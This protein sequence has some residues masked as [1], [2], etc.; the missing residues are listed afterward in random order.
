MNKLYTNQAEKSSLSCIILQIIAEKSVFDTDIFKLVTPYN[1]STIN[2][3]LVLSIMMTSMQRRQR[4]PPASSSFYSEI[5]K[6]VVV[7]KPDVEVNIY[8]IH[9]AAKD[10]DVEVVRASLESDLNNVNLPD[11]SGYSPL[12]IA[13][14]AGQIN[15]LHLLIKAGAYVDYKDNRGNTALHHAA[16]HG[17]VDAITTLIE[18]GAKVNQTTKPR[19]RLGPRFGDSKFNYGDT[20]LHIAAR[21]GHVKIIC[22]LIDKGAIVNQTNNNGETP[23]LIAASNNQVEAISALITNGADL[24]QPD[25]YDR[26]PFCVAA[27][28]G[29]VKAIKL[30]KRLGVDVNR[31]SKYRNTALH[32]AARRGHIDV[33][34]TLIECF[35]ELNQRNITG[36]SPL[37]IAAQYGHVSVIRVML[38]HGANVNL[39]NNKVE[40]P[41]SI[42]TQHG[43]VSVIKALIEHGVTV[44]ITPLLI[45]IKLDNEDATELLIK[46]GSKLDYKNKYGNTLLH[47]AAR[48]GCLKA[49]NVLIKHGVDVNQPIKPNEI[50]APR[51]K[52]YGRAP[53]FGR[54]YM[55]AWIGNDG[56]TALY[57]AASRGYMEIINILIACGA[58]VYQPIKNG[59]TAYD[60]AVKK[61]YIIIAS[62]LVHAAVIQP[63]DDN[64]NTVLHHAVINNH[65]DMIAKMKSVANRFKKWS[66]VTISESSYIVTGSLLAKNNNGKTAFDLIQT[67]E[68]ESDAWI[69]RDHLRSFDCAFIPENNQSHIVEKLRLRE[70]NFISPDNYQNFLQQ[71]RYDSKTLLMLAVQLGDINLVRKLLDKNNQIDYVGEDGNTAAH[72]AVLSNR[73]QIVDLFMH[74]QNAAVIR[75]KT[76]LDARTPLTLAI[77]QGKLNLIKRMIEKAWIPSSESVEYLSPLHVAFRNTDKD[78]LDYLIS[79]QKNSSHPFLLKHNNTDILHQAIRSKSIYNVMQALKMLRTL[80]YDFKPHNF[81]EKSF[82]TADTQ[83]HYYAAIAIQENFSQALRELFKKKINIGVTDADELSLLRFAIDLGHMECIEAIVSSL[84]AALD[85]SDTSNSSAIK[86]IVS[87][88]PYKM[89]EF[90]FEKMQELKLIDKLSA[91][92][93][94]NLIN[95]GRSRDDY[96]ITNLCIKLFSRANTINTLN[97]LF[98]LPNKNA[99]MAIQHQLSTSFTQS[100][101]INGQN[102]LHHAVCRSRKSLIPILIDKGVDVYGKD[103]DGYTPFHK[104]V[105]LSKK[106][107]VKYFFGNKAK[108]RIELKSEKDKLE[109]LKCAID[110]NN[111]NIFKMILSLFSKDEILSFKDDDGSPIFH[112][113][114][115]S[116]NIDYLKIYIRR[117]P[118][119]VAENSTSGDTILHVLARHNEAFAYAFLDWLLQNTNI[120]EILNKTNKQNCY[121]PLHVACDA[122]NVVFAELLLAQSNIFVDE[123]TNDEGLK[124]IDIAY[125]TRV[126]KIIQLFFN[127]KKLLSL[128][129]LLIEDY[130]YRSNS[131]HELDEVS[132]FLIKARVEQFALFVNNTHYWRRNLSNVQMPGIERRIKSRIHDSKI[133]FQL[134]VND[135]SCIMDAVVFSQLAREFVFRLHGDFMHRGQLSRDQNKDDVH[136]LVLFKD[137]DYVYASVDSLIS[138]LENEKITNW[139]DIYTRREPREASRLAR[140]AN[141]ATAMGRHA[142]Q[143][144]KNRGGP[145]NLNASTLRIL[146]EGVL[147]S[148]SSSRRVHKALRQNSIELIHP[149]QNLGQMYKHLVQEHSSQIKNDFISCLELELKQAFHAATAILEGRQTRAARKLEAFSKRAGFTLTIAHDLANLLPAADNDIVSQATSRTATGISVVSALVKTHLDR[150]ASKRSLAIRDFLYDNPLGLGKHYYDRDFIMYL[151]RYIYW[152]YQNQLLFIDS[153]T[154]SLLKAARV[155]VGRIVNEITEGDNKKLV[156][157]DIQLVEGE[158]EVRKQFALLRCIR[159]VRKSTIG[160]EVELTMRNGA[161]FGMVNAGLLYTGVGYHCGKFYHTKGSKT[162]K[163]G[164]AYATLDLLQAHKNVWLDDIDKSPLRSIR[165]EMDYNTNRPIGL[166]ISNNDSSGRDAKAKQEFINFFIQNLESAFDDANSIINNEQARAKTTTDTV[167]NASAAVAKISLTG[168]SSILR[169]SGIAIDSE[170]SVAKALI[171]GALWGAN[172]YKDKQAKIRAERILREF[173]EF[174]GGDSFDRYNAELFRYLAETIYWRYENQF[175]QLSPHST[176]ISRIAATAV[177][178]IVDHIANGK[179]QHR[180][181]PDNYFSNLVNNCSTSM[182]Y[183][184]RDK[185]DLFTR[186]LRALHHSKIGED[187]ALVTNSDSSNTQWTADGMLRCVGLNVENSYYKV[188]GKSDIDTYQFSRATTQEIQKREGLTQL[189]YDEVNNV[190]SDDKWIPY[191][192][193]QSQRD[194]GYGVGLSF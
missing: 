176:N 178:K 161:P 156:Q 42:A 91:D 24:N 77:E 146:G 150:N 28:E 53:T 124:P 118:N 183:Q 50:T 82:S 68:N 88:S 169:K 167:M 127:R 3:H 98:E 151:S 186:C 172:E 5:F 136:G 78:V 166:S 103:N 115:C 105:L 38:K 101:D 109:L 25:R 87:N 95:L 84:N 39:C 149:T 18:C 134:F 160:N 107:M 158:I 9:R 6:N 164:Y 102:A 90:I 72:Y 184:K 85:F 63:P 130:V 94:E 159:A 141:K 51:L 122:S 59:S 92:L 83:T 174:E 104:A 108:C 36:E 31:K 138:S 62:M 175:I 145:S 100:V 153:G 44:G 74:H 188:K 52:R 140:S 65:V 180:R 163:Y 61:G 111:N 20:A 185:R 75:G 168:I 54:A 14:Q 79:M 182:F 30:L 12:L 144:F 86:Y 64:G 37:S 89:I 170:V 69:I 10:G 34:T 47:V 142:K 181:Q 55:D 157:K 66:R 23:L 177:A 131:N 128:E 58:D 132:E 76:N 133:L 43:H 81:S 143:S 2:F 56:D 191:Y 162:T 139:V 171:T 126:L 40:S 41:L 48:F 67:S 57:I 35:A 96:E 114:C 187:V 45:A 17:H 165:D 97:D 99:R 21:Y 120:S 4:R 15:V 148:L 135:D 189:P 110:Q 119:V 46:H 137:L 123:A 193:F 8:A 125:K 32:L 49:I 60:V 73:E 106:N 112:L 152:Q 117:S 190:L 80:K 22:A 11:K 155:V 27:Q 29:Q 179:G 129:T 147:D 93:R 26:T 70:D 7:E 33:I 16:Q 71:F 113:I 154:D 173:S 1:L 194:T 192:D 19:P 116:K 13:A 121:T